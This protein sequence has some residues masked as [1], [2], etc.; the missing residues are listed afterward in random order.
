[1]DHRSRIAAECEAVTAWLR[2]RLRR[3]APSKKLVLTFG[4]R[5]VG[6]GSKGPPFGTLEFPTERTATGPR[7][8]TLETR[9][10]PWDLRKSPSTNGRATEKI[11]V[12]SGPA[13]ERGSTGTQPLWRSAPVT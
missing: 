11:E 5:I 1:M 13:T 3:A 10:L 7:V 9:L 8:G 4:N 6:V 2:G 12:Y